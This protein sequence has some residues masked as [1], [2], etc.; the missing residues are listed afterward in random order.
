[1]KLDDWYVPPVGWP[2]RNDA[3][4]SPVEPGFVPS[5]AV[6]AL[7]KVNVPPVLLFWK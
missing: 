1:M 3:K 2:I 6:G 7:V 4:G 5:S